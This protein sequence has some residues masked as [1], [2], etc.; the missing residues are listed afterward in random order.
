MNKMILW[1]G[2]VLALTNGMNA[3]ENGQAFE[4]RSSHKKKNRKETTGTAKPSIFELLSL[5]SSTQDTPLTVGT[6]L[7]FDDLN[8]TIS[9]SH[10]E[11]DETGTQFTLTGPGT[12]LVE[13]SGTLTV[14]FADT[15]AVSIG[16]SH[17]SGNPL[18]P[19]GT[20]F[21]YQPGVAQVQCTT[22]YSVSQYIGLSSA[23][24]TTVFSINATANS[25]TAQNS[26][27]TNKVINITRVSD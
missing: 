3:A 9:E 1:C 19:P 5:N 25:A 10:I 26:Y 27:I 24:D 11:V 12:F 2:V 4:A 21:Q 6:A 13:T 18:P 14:N 8:L 7:V 15:D 20:L 22:G 23:S 17:I 16:L